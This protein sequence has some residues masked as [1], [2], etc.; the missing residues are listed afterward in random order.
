MDRTEEHKEKHMRDK[1]DTQENSRTG[2]VTENKVFLI[3]ITQR[4]TAENK[5]NK[6]QNDDIMTW[7]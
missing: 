5:R 3:E 6:P 2:H 4:H 7:H 1:R